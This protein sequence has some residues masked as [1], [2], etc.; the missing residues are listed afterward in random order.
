[1]QN[2][3]YCSLYYFNQWVAHDRIYHDALSSGCR[4]KKLVALKK[5]AAFYGIARNLK[6]EFD[7]QK[8]LA[9]CE[10]VLDVIDF[11]TTDDFNED[12]VE[13]ISRVEKKISSLYGGSG[14]LSLT[15]KFLWLKLRDPIVIY[16]SRARKAL[17]TRNGDLASYYEEWRKCFAK[18]KEEIKSVCAKLPACHL[19]VFDQT[20]GTVPYLE[21]IAS[22]NWFHERV[23]DVYLWHRD[24]P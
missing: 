6:K 15:T 14:V 12:L 3:E 7:E 10:P 8:G 21:E 22:Q 11:L 18:H 1:M 23:F 5:A 24:S 20:V 4:A 16:D 9:R 13:E 19:Y 2:F 17:R